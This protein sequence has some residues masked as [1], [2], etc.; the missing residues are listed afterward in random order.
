MS[1]DGSDFNF[2]YRVSFTQKEEKIYWNYEVQE[3]SVTD[4]QGVSVFYRNE[5]GEI[6]HTYSCYSRG[7]D[8]LNC[9]YQYLDPV[10]KGR[11]EDGFTF[12]MEWVR[13]HDQYGNTQ[14]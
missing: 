3:R 2:D 13:R 12:P 4:E 10:P 6:F 14:K 8:P 9:A 1:S 5:Q 11:D 7:I